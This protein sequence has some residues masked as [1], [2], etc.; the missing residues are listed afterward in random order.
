MT[1]IGKKLQDK[2]PIPIAIAWKKIYLS[3]NNSDALRMCMNLLE[4]FL[5]YTTGILLSAYL[6]GDPEK[7]VE[8]YLHKLKK[9]N[10]GDYAYLIRHIL[11]SF[12][13]DQT[14]A[15]R[16]GRRGRAL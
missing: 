13:R 12:H 11:K 4:T 10:Y 8:E 16:C 14:R 6:R 2:L 3:K 5:Q 1:P 9:P 7:K 15:T